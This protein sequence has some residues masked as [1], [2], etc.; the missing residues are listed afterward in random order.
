MFLPCH[1]RHLYNDTRSDN[2]AIKLLRAM[3]AMSCQRLCCDLAMTGL[4]VRK[5]KAILVNYYLR[6]LCRYTSFCN[7]VTV[8]VRMFIHIILQL[9]SRTTLRN[10]KQ[11]LSMQSM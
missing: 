7:A 9:E 2:K 5:Y 11:D 10:S 8:F 6:M 1:F 3:T 4:S